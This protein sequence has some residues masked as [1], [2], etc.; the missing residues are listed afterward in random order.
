MEVHDDKRDTQAK[1]PARQTR[2]LLVG[3]ALTQ[4]SRAGGVGGVRR[5]VFMSWTLY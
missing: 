5:S 4:I 3:K 2:L 1:N